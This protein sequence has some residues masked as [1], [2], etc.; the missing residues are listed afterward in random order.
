MAEVIQNDAEKRAQLKEVVRD[1]HAGSDLKAIRKKFG[2][3]IENTSPEEI[4]AMEQDL[5]REGLTPADIQLVCDVHVAVFEQQLKKQGKAHALPGHPV[6]T[7]REENRYLRRLLRRMVW[8]A[9]GVARGGDPTGFREILEDLGKFEIHYQ[10]KENQLFPYLEQVGFDGPSKVMWGKHDEVR[11]EFKALRAALDSGNRREV[12]RRA[13]SLRRTMKMMIFMEERILFPTALRKL[14]DRYWVQIRHGESAI[15]YAWIT[16]G[17]T[18]DPSVVL[19]GQNI[20]RQKE[21]AEAVRKAWQRNT[22][23]K[24][25]DVTLNIPYGASG[26]LSVGAGDAGSS[27]DALAAGLEDTSAG[28][29]PVIQ[30]SVGALRVSEIDMILKSL[31]VDISYVDESDRVRYYS[32]TPERVFP[33]SP[34]IIGRTVQNCHPP[35]SVHMVQEIV[36]AFKAGERDRAEFWLTIKDRFIHIAYLALRDDAGRYRGVLE[37]GQD[38]THLRSLEGEQRL[39]AWSD[40]NQSGNTS[41]S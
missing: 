29:D 7:Y 20:A 1:L 40:S 15:G 41:T 8:S 23:V 13:R 37:V 17:D 31:P 33:R 14:N 10:R 25:Q 2:K 12:K 38:G 16:P 27:D 28:D 11:A 3:L 22:R 6:H 21:E 19:A 30:L 9:R 24:L 4:A 35:R 18:W 32:D 36:R 34:G 26:D 39:L 5:M